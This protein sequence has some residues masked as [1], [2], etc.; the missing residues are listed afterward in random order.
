MLHGQN[1]ITAVKGS[2]S[3]ALFIDEVLK[4]QSVR[5]SVI[6]EFNHTEPIKQAAEANLGIGIVPR[7]AAEREL[8][9][10]RLFSLAVTGMSLARDLALA[11]RA[12]KLKEPLVALV[13]GQVKGKL[14]RSG[15][16]A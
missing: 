11:Y 3:H 15:A 4:R 9:E 2:G 14:S 12:P 8:A 1:F 13:V 10:R 7:M 6:M 5:A 16:A